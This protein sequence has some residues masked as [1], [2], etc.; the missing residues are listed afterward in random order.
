MGGNTDRSVAHGKLGVTGI[1]TRLVTVFFVGP[2]GVQLVI[3]L[4]LGG[5]LCVGL[6]RIGLLRIGLL[7]IGLLHICL[8]WIGAVGCGRTHT[9]RGDDNSTM[10]TLHISEVR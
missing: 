2:V 7:R 10:K 1:A 5:V 9:H 3:C 4:L 8:L 6:L